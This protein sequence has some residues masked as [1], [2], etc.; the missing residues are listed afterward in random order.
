MHYI[1]AFSIQVE[2]TFGE[3]LLRITKVKLTVLNL[4]NVVL[5]PAGT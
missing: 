4:F 3:P 1:A 5:I 2:C